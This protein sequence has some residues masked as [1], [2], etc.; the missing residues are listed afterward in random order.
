MEWSNELLFKV[1]HNK[2][3]LVLEILNKNNSLDKELIKDVFSNP[4]N[5]G[6][7]I[8][9]IIKRIEMVNSPG[10]IKDEIVE[11]LKNANDN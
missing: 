1:A 6:F 3:D 9:E 2:P 11:S 10:T 7:D 4:V 8:A 5:S